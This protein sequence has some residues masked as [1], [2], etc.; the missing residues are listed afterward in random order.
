MEV[1]VLNWWT[2]WQ[3]SKIEHAKNLK[4]AEMRRRSRQKS[5]DHNRLNPFIHLILDHLGKFL[6]ATGLFLQRRFGTLTK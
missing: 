6:V 3:L 4:N 5:D 2:I 1:E